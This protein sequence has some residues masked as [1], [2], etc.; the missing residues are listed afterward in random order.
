MASHPLPEERGLTAT[1]DNFD[2]MY[3]SLNMQRISV[4]LQIL[5]FISV[6]NLWASLDLGPRKDF[7]KV[8][9][10]EVLGLK[11]VEREAI[12]EKI[13]LQKGMVLDNHLLKKYLNTIYSLKYFES[14]EAHHEKK[15]GENILVFKVTERPIISTITIEGNSK[16]SEKELKEKIKTK[17]FSI[18]DINT[19]KSDVKEMLKYYEEKGFYLANI[20]HTLKKIDKENVELL[21]NIK[22]F[23]KIRIKKI[24]FL[25]NRAFGDKQLQD[26]METREEGLFSFMSG[27]GNFKEFSFQT[28]IERIKYFYKTKGYLQINVGV[29][30]ITVSANRKW[31]F[32]TI[33]V[34]EGPQFTIRNISFQGEM[35]FSEDKLRESIELRSDETYS[36]DLLRRDIQKLTELYQDEGYAFTNVLRTLHVVPGENKVDIEFSFEKGKIVYFGRITV[37]GNTKTRDKVIRRELKIQEG[38]K[39]S[40]TKLRE[41]R[42]NINRLGFFEVGSVIFNTI[43]PEEKNDVL[44]VEIHV[45][46]RNTGQ[47]SLGAGYST[48]M[49]SSIHAS[50]S[51]N[52]FRG[53]GQNLS[54]S[55]AISDYDQTFNLGLTEPYFNDTKWTVGGDIFKTKNTSLSSFTYERK[56]FNLRAGHPIF[57]YTRLFATYKLEQT[58]LKGVLDSTVEPDLENGIASSIRLALIRDKRNNSFEPSAGHYLSFATEYTGLGGDKKWWKNES[59]GR[60][61]RRWKD[62]VFRHRLYIGQLSR[63]DGMGI[64]RTERFYLGGARNLRG[65]DYEAIGPLKTVVDDQGREQ[66]FNSGSLFSSFAQI[67]VEHPLAQEAGLKWVLFTDAGDANSLKNFKVYVDYGF[68]LRWFSPIGV[69]RFE[70][71]IPLTKDRSG[72]GQFHFDL[73]QLF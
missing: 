47:I 27:S 62:F 34:H 7:F 16:I 67:E 20:N 35:L 53:L 60:Y 19:V 40:G 43:T 64:P 8:D 29:P 25:G 55:L 37:I 33:R 46:E 22:E 42:E 26:I 41:S 68:G 61:Y 11:K 17:E 72:G 2:S 21:F 18:L 65:Y 24:A 52:N 63:I 71:G 6:N 44:N 15:G 59:D 73:G 66:E 49:G 30:E 39:Y 54:F 45:K 23:D 32:I 48:A 31:I 14:V 70:Y 12:L 9:K 13:S 10:I 38:V 50:I 1:L 3:L 51:Q 5:F 57:E 56:G 58:S 4:L 28:D 36:E 69:M